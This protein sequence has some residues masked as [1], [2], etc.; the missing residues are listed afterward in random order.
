M[1]NIIIKLRVSEEQEEAL[2]LKYPNIKYFLERVIINITGKIIGTDGF[3]KID[4][5]EYHERQVLNSGVDRLPGQPYWKNRKHTQATK[6]KISSSLKAK[7]W[8][9]I[10]LLEETKKLISLD[11]KG[12]KFTEEHRKNISK[13]LK[14]F[15]RKKLCVGRKKNKVVVPLIVF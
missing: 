12:K 6:D 13:S 8:K 10:S 9:G 11:H 7:N 15:N 2:L 1:N 5:E 14:A 3:N 4:I